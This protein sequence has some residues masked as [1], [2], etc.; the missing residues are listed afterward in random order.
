MPANRVRQACR[1]L[2]REV[3][4]CEPDVLDTLNDLHVRTFLDCAP[5]PDFEI[6]Q[7]WV[8]SEHGRPVGFAGMIPSSLGRGIAYLSR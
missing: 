6:G 7:W 5:L 8:S 3:D 2:I 1:F 4:A